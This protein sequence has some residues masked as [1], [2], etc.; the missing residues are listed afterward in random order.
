MIENI[1]HKNKIIE[2]KINPFI[3]A[4]FDAERKPKLYESDLIKQHKIEEANQ[5]YC[6]DESNENIIKF[7]E[8]VNTKLKEIAAMPD[9]EII[10]SYEI[11]DQAHKNPYKNQNKLSIQ[12]N[13]NSQI[14][15]NNGSI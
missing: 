7:W 1:N 15:C 13:N 2:N 4:N 5:P 3:D 8:C 10:E 6:I 9:N 11:D 14:Q 12:I